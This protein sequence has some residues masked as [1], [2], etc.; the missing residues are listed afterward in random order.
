MRTELSLSPAALCSFLVG[1]E[2]RPWLP[3][4][5]ARVCVCACAHG[6]LCVCVC[7]VYVCVSVCCVFLCVSVWLC[8]VC[9]H[10]YVFAYV[11]LCCVCMYVSVCARVCV[12]CVLCACLC[13]LVYVSLCVC[14]VYT[15]VCLYVYVHVSL[16]DVCLCVCTHTYACALKNCWPQWGQDSACPMEGPMRPC[17]DS[18]PFSAPELLASLKLTFSDIAGTEK[19]VAKVNMITH[20]KC[21]RASHVRSGY[22]W[23][24]YGGWAP[25]SWPA[26]STFSLSC[27][28]G[29]QLVGPFLLF[30]GSFQIRGPPLPPRLTETM[31]RDPDS[32]CLH[33]GSG[34]NV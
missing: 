11:S 4:L 17:T 3:H 18:A 14:C 12:A 30:E 25:S 29:E 21:G 22:P 28:S 9:V 20:V 7:G 6:G 2:K 32:K 15:C 23:V 31:P 8:V 5:H 33:M 24:G 27:H 16:C 19:T 1:E 34:L 10:V 13:V 26:D